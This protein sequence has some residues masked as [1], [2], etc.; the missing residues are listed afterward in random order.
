MDGSAIPFYNSEKRPTGTSR[1]AP[2]AGVSRSGT[3]L[4][5]DRKED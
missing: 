5:P 3:V 1:D 4:L 2:R